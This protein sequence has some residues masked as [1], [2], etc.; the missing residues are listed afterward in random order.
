MKFIFV[1]PIRL[2]LR[3]LITSYT[4]LFMKPLKRNF[5]LVLIVGITVLPLGNW[6]VFVL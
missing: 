4:D 1:S 3:T 6:F 5:F 2:L